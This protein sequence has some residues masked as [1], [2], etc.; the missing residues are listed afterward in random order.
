MDGLHPLFREAGI[1][2]ILPEAIAGSFTDMLLRGGTRE[3]L[4]ELARRFDGDGAWKISSVIL[5]EILPPLTEESPALEMFVSGGGRE[6]FIRRHYVAFSERSA[7]LEPEPEPGDEGYVRWWMEKEINRQGLQSAAEP[8]FME[9]LKKDQ[10]LIREMIDLFLSA[11]GPNKNAPARERSRAFGEYVM[12]RKREM[13]GQGRNWGSVKEG[14][15]FFGPGQEAYKE[16]EEI[17]G[18]HE[19]LFLEIMGMVRQKP[20]VKICRCQKCGRF[21]SPANLKTKYCSEGCLKAAKQRAQAAYAAKAVGKPNELYRKAQQTFL[22]YLKNCER[23]G[24]ISGEEAKEKRKVWNIEANK[25]LNEALE[26]EKGGNY[27][28]TGD[29]KGWLVSEHER[30]KNELRGG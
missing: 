6:S 19:I 15:T 17:G 16:Y 11:G 24:E 12:E 14:F 27:E 22:K 1:D 10:S 4:N 29:F 8:G 28:V 30:L 2:D 21:F 25:R 9:G 3:K 23:R 18:L 13:R 20:P 5:G 26:A 7:L